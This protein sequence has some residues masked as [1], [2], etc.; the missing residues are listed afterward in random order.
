VREYMIDIL[1]V[2]LLS[3]ICL[4]SISAGDTNVFIRGEKSY[5]FVSEIGSVICCCK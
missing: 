1:L 5:T 3:W 4:T 2:D